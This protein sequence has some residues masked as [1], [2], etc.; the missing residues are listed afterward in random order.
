MIASIASS[1]TRTTRPRC[2][3]HV[4][5]QREVL[6][7]GMRAGADARHALVHDRRRVRHRPHDGHAVG[8]A[9]LDVRGRDRRR[10]REDGLLGCEQ[11]PISLEQRVDVLR[12]HRDDD[13][14]GAADRVARSTVVASTPWRSCS[15]ATR[16]SRRRG[17]DDVAPAGAEQA[18]EQ[19]LADAAAA[20]DRDALAWRRGYA[21]RGVT[22]RARANSRRAD[23]RSRARPTRR[24]ARAAPPSPSPR[25][26]GR[27][28]RA[29]SLTS[30]RSPTSP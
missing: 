25:P 7:A 21:A 17:D 1:G 18:G 3:Q 4:F 11:R 26:A 28:A 29:G 20:D 8:D 16:S 12:L 22:A 14:R 2:A 15:S 19:R 6:V 5:R 27:A 30:P 9:R 23:T 24:T 13:D 10:D